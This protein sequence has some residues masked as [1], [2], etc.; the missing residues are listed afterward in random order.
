MYQLRRESCASFKDT[1]FLIEGEKREEVALELSC[2]VY[3]SQC[4]SI[5]FERNIIS[6]T[7]RD[8]L[9]GSVLHIISL[10]GHGICIVDIGV[11]L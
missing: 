4:G 11:R 9:S 1:R 2:R 5:S 3:R 6:H 7:Y 10:V 8:R